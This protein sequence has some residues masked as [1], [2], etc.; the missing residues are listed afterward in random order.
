MNKVQENFSFFDSLANINITNRPLVF[1]VSKRI[2][3]FLLL[4]L[5]SFFVNLKAKN[6]QQ[7]PSSKLKMVVAKAP[8]G[9]QNKAKARTAK[10]KVKKAKAAPKDT[11]REIDPANTSSPLYEKNQI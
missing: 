2:S 4:L 9:N 3:F 6:I 5:S 11:I 10:T 1:S 7:I 8:K